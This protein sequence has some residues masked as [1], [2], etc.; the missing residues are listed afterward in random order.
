MEFEERHF[1]RSNIWQCVDLKCMCVQQSD[2]KAE[3]EQEDGEQSKS[4]D[5]HRLY[6]DGINGGQKDCSNSGEVSR[7]CIQ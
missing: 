2:A 7:L 4:G 6:S 5:L 1:T 3:H